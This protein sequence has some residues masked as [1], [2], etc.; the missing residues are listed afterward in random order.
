M[1]VLISP[2]VHE[3][4]PEA[5][6]LDPQHPML[7]QEYVDMAV[8]QIT[9]LQQWRYWHARMQEVFD[10]ISSGALDDDDDDQAANRAFQSYSHQTSLAR[11]NWK[12]TEFYLHLPS[13]QAHP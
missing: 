12:Q 7:E 11:N 8:A 2:S 1:K 6:D 5:R 13:V 4:M 3:Q 10:R 9:P